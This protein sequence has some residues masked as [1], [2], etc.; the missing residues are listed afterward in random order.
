MTLIWIGRSSGTSTRAAVEQWLARDPLLSME[1]GNEGTGSSGVQAP[2]G[3]RRR[4][5][6]SPVGFERGNEEEAGVRRQGSRRSGLLML[7]RRGNRR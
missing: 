5:S 4:R 6:S 7:I 2:G 3:A 1:L